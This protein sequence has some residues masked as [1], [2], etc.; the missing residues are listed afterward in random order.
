MSGSVNEQVKNKL[1]GRITFAGA[2]QVK[3]IAEAVKTYEVSEPAVQH[4]GQRVVAFLWQRGMIAGAAYV[5]TSW[6]LVWGYGRLAGSVNAPPWLLPAMI[7]LLA[8]GFIPAIAIAWRPVGRQPVAPWVRLLA[9]LL[10]TVLG[11][12]VVWSAWRDY[13]E[14]TSRNAITRPVPKAQPVVA[15]GAVQN[16]TGDPKLDWLSEGI[17]NLVRDGLAESNHLVVVSPRRWQAV[18]RSQE[19]G[20]GASGDVFA[21]AAR[22]GIDY[23]VSGEFLSGP[24][25]LLLTAR[26]TDIDRD[27]ELVANRSSP[28][29]TQQ[30]LLGEADRL[31]LMAKSALRVPHTESVG[32]YAADFAVN[33]MAAY[34]AYVGGIGHLLKFDYRSADLAFRKALELAPEFHMARYRLAQV[35]VVSGDTEAALATLDQIP[36]DAPLTR[37]ERFYVDGAHALFARDVE[38]ESRFTLGA[39]G[40]P[41][42]PSGAGCFS[43]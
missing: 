35:Q 29:L 24:E 30:S 20:S 25:G 41:V 37:R 17:A 40:I 12:T 32:S 36:Q 15:V 13:R 7:T 26:L 5:V 34:E 16:L 27:I 1:D 14:E 38:R 10:A 39:R 6:L 9:V 42:R 2:R 33:N 3:N 23:V 43:C 18:L 21:S 19:N 28:D 4:L 11:A 22:A 8:V 31:V